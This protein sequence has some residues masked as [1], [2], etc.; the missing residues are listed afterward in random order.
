MP[1]IIESKKRRRRVVATR[2]PALPLFMTASRSRL[3][4]RVSMSAPVCREMQSYIRWG[5]EVSRFSSEE[6]QVMMLDRA[7]TDY[8]KKD[9][10]WQAEKTRRAA[11]GA[12]P[13]AEGSTASE[14]PAQGR[15]GR[16]RGGDG[17]QD[18]GGTV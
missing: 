18:P 1:A 16:A 15:D 17:G 14:A 8:L 2:S 12:G 11:E 7:L 6:V 4:E 9:G 5:V 3:T 13:M 10:A